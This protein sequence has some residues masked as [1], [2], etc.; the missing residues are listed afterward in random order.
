MVTFLGGSAGSTNVATLLILR[1]FAGT[2]GASPLVNSGGTIA[3]L[4]M[5]AQRGLALTVYCVAPF[6]GPILGPVMGGFISEN[7]GWRWVQGVCTIFIGIVG[8]LG[9]IFLPETY[10]PVLLQKRARFLSQKSAKV[11]ISVLEKSQG[12][13]RPSEVFKIA[14]F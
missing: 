11:Y 9:A 14:L 10:G 6:L 4:F 2:F 7:I 5:P 13:K 8:I 3:D 1:F 12:K